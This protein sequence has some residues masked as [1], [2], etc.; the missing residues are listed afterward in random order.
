MKI[1]AYL[2]HWPLWKRLPRLP[3]GLASDYDQRQLDRDTGNLMALTR[4]RCPSGAQT[5]AKKHKST[6]HDLWVALAPAGKRRRR[7]GRRFTSLMRRAM[8]L[9]PHD[10]LARHRP[11][12]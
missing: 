8:G 10:P 6:Q 4:T 11:R 3:R 12:R 2:L 7:P 9:T 1:I 5:L